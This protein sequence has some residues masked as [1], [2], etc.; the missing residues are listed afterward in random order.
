MHATLREAADSHGKEIVLWRG[1]TMVL[2]PHPLGLRYERQTN[3]GALGRNESF[4]VHDTIWK[5]PVPIV[6]WW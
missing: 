2:I 1:H 6:Y 5:G 3:D 4:E